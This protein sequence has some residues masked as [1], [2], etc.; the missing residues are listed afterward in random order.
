[1]SIGSG[2]TNQFGQKIGVTWGTAVTPD[3]FAEANSVTL[4]RDKNTAQG[5]GLYNGK[6]L[7][8]GARRV[9][10]TTGSSGSVALDMVDKGIGLFLQGLMGSTATPVIISGSAYTQTHTLA[11]SVGK[12]YTLQTGVPNTAGTIQPYTFASAKVIGAEFSCGVDEILTGT[13]DY[14]G[15]APITGTA[16]ASA[17]YTST[18]RPF[19][20]GDATIKIGTYAS[21]A[22]ISHV[23]K[24]SVKIDRPHAVDRFYYGAAGVRAEPLINGATQISV[25]LDFDFLG[26]ATF[27]DLYDADTATSMVIEFVGPTA[28]SGSNYPTFRITLPQVYFNTGTP[29]VEG[30]DVVSTS[31]EGV[32]LFDG[33]NL[34]TITVI[35][36]DVTL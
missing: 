6:L 10:T 20:F 26:K 24:V 19:N 31:V 18:L 14:I 4:V 17:S 25:S 32:C 23:K 11:D 13:F 36:S 2:L 7:N 28:I 3:H 27:A 9:V 29:T 8:R 21:E 34:P 22:S 16:L 33:T 1:M 30:E 5:E 12:F 15:T 35:S